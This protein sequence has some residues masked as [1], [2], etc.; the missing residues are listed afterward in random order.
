MDP[1]KLIA[2]NK[3]REAMEKGDFDNLYGQGKPIDFNADAHIP[4]EYRMAHKILQNSGF[5]TTDA[6]LVKQIQ[7]L[8]QE[9]EST[10]TDSATSAI[11]KIIKRKE[12]ELLARRNR[13]RRVQ[14]PN[15]EE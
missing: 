8:K 12:A 3:I 15:P 11:A 13:F 5:E 4:A 2:E 9:A 10:R 7:S 14:S 6:D 1:L